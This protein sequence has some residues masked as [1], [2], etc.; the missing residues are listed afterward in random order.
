MFEFQQVLADN[1]K[2]GCTFQAEIYR[3][4]QDGAEV[5][6]VVIGMYG[7]EVPPKVGEFAGYHEISDFMDKTGIDTWVR[8]QVV[9]LAHDGKRVEFDEN[10]SY[11]LGAAIEA[12][13]QVQ[14][15][16]P[17]SIPPNPSMN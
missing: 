10:P 9:Q 2:S 8:A 17:T 12:R 13:R 6:R 5:Y 14:G 16:A 11:R 15:F 7:A 3:S 4:M 1:V